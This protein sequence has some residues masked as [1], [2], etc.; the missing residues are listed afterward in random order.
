MTAM[1]Q[2]ALE[3]GITEIAFTEHFDGHPLDIC[4]HYYQPAQYFERLA[5]ARE[6]FAP[7]GLAIRAGVE[8]GEPHIYHA[9]QVPVLDQYPYDI[10]LGSLHWIG[11]DNVFDRDYFRT[12]DLK[13]VLE[14]YFTELEQVVRAGGFD[15]L[16]HA[17]VFKRAAFGVYGPQD[18]TNWEDWVRPVWQACIETGIG[19]EINTAPL[20]RGVPEVHPGPAMLRWYREM[21]GEILTLGSDAH[22]PDHVGWALED[23]VDLAR[24]A[25][26]ERVAIF[27]GRQ[28]VRWAAI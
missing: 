1:C 6:R 16:A 26:F 22:Q 10:V 9:E 19:I 14:A 15:V 8:L 2:S 12:H 7:Q 18:T 5:A 24:A 25:G 23:A 3:R 27:E 11:N 20:R 13:S 17:D 21:G 28:V 4:R